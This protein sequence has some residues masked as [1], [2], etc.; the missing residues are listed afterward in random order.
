MNKADLAAILSDRFGLTKKDAAAAIDA[1]LDEITRSVAKGTPVAISGFGTFK[2]QAV[3]ARKA[4]VGRNPQ[5]GEPVTIAAKKASHKP[6]FTPAKALKDVVSGA[7][8]L[9]AP[10]KPKKK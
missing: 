2:K 8:K 9:P 5:T 4:R 10:A 7:V 6:A 1:L 3:A